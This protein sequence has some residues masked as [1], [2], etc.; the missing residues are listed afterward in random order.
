ME[1]VFVLIIGG[2]VSVCAALALRRLKKDFAP[3]LEEE[4]EGKD[5]E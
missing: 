1:I 3:Y 4:R 5:H 2:W